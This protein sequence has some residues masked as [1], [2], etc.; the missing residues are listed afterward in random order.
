MPYWRLT[1]AAFLV[2]TLCAAAASPPVSPAA[3]TVTL[4][5]AEYE[6]VFTAATLNKQA[7]KFRHERQVLDAQSRELRSKL[8]QTR[9]DASRRERESADSSTAQEE[10]KRMAILK[11]NWLLLNHTVDGRYESGDTVPWRCSPGRA[12]W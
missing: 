1:V 9:E 10:T 4:T 7:D 5:L 3:S 11:D 2:A 12:S 6:K 8:E